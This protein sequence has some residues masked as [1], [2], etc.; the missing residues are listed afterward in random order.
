MAKLL[1][2][3]SGGI[4]DLRPPPPDPAHQ[5]PFLPEANYQVLGASVGLNHFQLLNHPAVYRQLRT[6]ITRRPRRVPSA[7]AASL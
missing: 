7:L 3:R 1:E 4:K 5:V 2:A 6:W